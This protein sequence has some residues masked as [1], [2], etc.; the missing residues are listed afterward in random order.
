VH[1]KQVGIFRSNYLCLY[2][3]EPKV[4]FQVPNFAKLLQ[5]KRNK[6]LKIVQIKW[7]N[8]LTRAIIGLQLSKMALDICLNQEK[9]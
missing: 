9:P 6:V 1:Y 7:I 2:L 3:Y 4:T 5:T 8:M